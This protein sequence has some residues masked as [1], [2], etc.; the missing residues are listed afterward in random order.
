MSKSLVEFLKSFC[1]KHDIS[2]E[3]FE[4][5]KITILRELYTAH[6]EGLD[7]GLEK[8]EQILDNSLNDS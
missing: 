7:K 5:L 4:R 3:D 8:F 6:A 2:A 1:E